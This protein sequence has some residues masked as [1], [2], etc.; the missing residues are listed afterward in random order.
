MN[1]SDAARNR[2]TKDEFEN[3]LGSGSRIIKR[4]VENKNPRNKLIPP[5][6]GFDSLLHLIVTSF[7][8]LIPSV[9]ENLNN[10]IF[11]INEIIAAPKKKSR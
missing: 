9:W 2:P 4:T 7:L 5:K 11:T 1:A 8:F 6:E 10:I 3:T